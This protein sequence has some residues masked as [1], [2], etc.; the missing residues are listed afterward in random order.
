MGRTR[1]DQFDDFPA[2][3]AAPFGPFRAIVEHVTDGDTIRCLVD[4]GFNEYRF[5]VVRL[6]GIDAP[7]RY[8]GTVEERQAGSMALSHLAL[9]LPIGTPV[10][11]QTEPDPDSFGR[12]IA[13]VTLADGTSVNERMVADGH[14]IER[15]Y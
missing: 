6:A 14:A 8:R 2:E 3:L 1:P 11:L 10:L 15:E 9:L 4:V 12:Y 5:T 7:E 13:T